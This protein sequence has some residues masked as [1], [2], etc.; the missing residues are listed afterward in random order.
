MKRW[1]APLALA[2]AAGCGAFGSRF[3]ISG[4]ITIAAPLR[5]RAPR[6]NMVLFVVAKNMGGVPVAVGRIVNP[7]FPVK[8][9]LT[10][11]DLLVPGSRP[12]DAL[13]IEVQM[14]THGNV[15]RPVKGDLEGF[16]PDPVYPGER[17]VNI[18]IDR[19]V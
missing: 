7:Q 18:V 9:T 8:F 3:V 10:E 14:N 4:T 17:G 5:S 2:A 15:G 16:L 19:Q 6:S 12:K 13:Q 1:L 11:E